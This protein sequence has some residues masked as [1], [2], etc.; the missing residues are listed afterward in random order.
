MWFPEGL[1]NTPFNKQCSGAHFGSFLFYYYCAISAGEN[2][3]F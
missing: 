3:L 1:E 2:K